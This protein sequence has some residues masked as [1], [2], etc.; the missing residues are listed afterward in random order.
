M[1]NQ[2]KNQV[3]NQ[4]A[5]DFQRFSMINHLFLFQ[6]S[7]F[8]LFLFFDRK[9]QTKPSHGEQETRRRSGGRAQ[10]GADPG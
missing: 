1:E 3:K 6:F 5:C 9:K 8:P 4:Q 10:A 2:P 7:A